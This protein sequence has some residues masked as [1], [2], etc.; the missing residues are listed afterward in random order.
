MLAVEDQ[1]PIIQ[2]TLEGS[3]TAPARSLHSGNLRVQ[4]CVF[5]LWGCVE[6]EAVQRPITHAQCFC[7]DHNRAPVQSLLTGDRVQYASFAEA[8]CQACVAVDE[9]TMG[10]LLVSPTLARH[11]KPNTMLYRRK[12]ARYALDQ[13]LLQLVTDELAHGGGTIS[14]ALHTW[15]NQHPEPLQQDLIM[16]PD[17]MHASHTTRALADAWYTSNA[18][19]FAGTAASGIVWSFTRAGNESSLLAVAPFVRSANIPVWPSTRAI[20]HGA[21]EKTHRGH[22]W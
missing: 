15:M 6:G 8:V 14:S 12:K 10:N 11:L 19:R 20:A 9:R 21:M 4:A 5:G 18:L 1:H 17:L 7:E 3:T 16:G 2:S 13:K 22:R